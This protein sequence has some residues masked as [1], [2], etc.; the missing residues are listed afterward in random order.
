MS[1]Y[2][3]LT[4]ACAIGYIPIPLKNILVVEDQ[5]AYTKPMAA[6]IVKV[7]NVPYEN[8]EFVLEFDDPRMETSC[9]E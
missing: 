1:A 8:D 9:N 5:S 7:A 4:T 6:E 3:S 2:L